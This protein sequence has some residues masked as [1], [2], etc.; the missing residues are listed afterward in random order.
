MLQK[1]LEAVREREEAQKHLNSLLDSDVNKKHG[2]MY[3]NVIMKMITDA[4]VDTARR[5]VC[6]WGQTCKGSVAASIES[7]RLPTTARVIFGR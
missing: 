4:R 5:Q 7:R 6:H 1:V 3:R 2:F